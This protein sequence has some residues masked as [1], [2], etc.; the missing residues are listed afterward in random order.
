MGA[1]SGEVSCERS[2]GV[3]EQVPSRPSLRA[4]SHDTP[5]PDVSSPCGRTSNVGRTVAR[6]VP[7]FV[8]CSFMCVTRGVLA[9]V[10]QKGSARVRVVSQARKWPLNAT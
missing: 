2:A 5:G 8:P 6:A 4:I 9:A 3:V 1:R 10:S 7:A